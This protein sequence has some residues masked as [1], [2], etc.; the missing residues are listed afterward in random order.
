[1][2]LIFMLKGISNLYL[3]NKKPKKLRLYFFITAHV[4]RPIRIVLA[5]RLEH[6]GQQ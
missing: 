5:G 6:V 2:V 1:M 3:R 4:A